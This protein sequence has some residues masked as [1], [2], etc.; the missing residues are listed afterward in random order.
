MWFL[1]RRGLD[2]KASLLSAHSPRL[3]SCWGWDGGRGWGWSLEVSWDTE[4]AHTGDDLTGARLLCVT[5]QHR[6]RSLTLT[7][8]QPRQAEPTRLILTAELGWSQT[9][10]EDLCEAVTRAGPWTTW[11]SPGPSHWPHQGHCHPV[12]TMGLGQLQHQDRGQI[13]RY[14][15]QSQLQK[16]SWTWR[17]CLH[18]GCRHVSW[19]TRAT[20][21]V[22]IV[23]CRR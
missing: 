10:N 5:V 8:R 20:C 9:V 23:T 22:R 19:V 16:W 7:S 13:L 4:A 18:D 11:V 21:G 1:V 3:S 12:L 2:Y 14:S 6:L 15:G 17:W